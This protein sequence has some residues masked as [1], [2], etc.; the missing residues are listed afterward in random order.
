MTVVRPFRAVRYDTKRVDLSKVIVPPY[1][2]IAV[3]ERGSFFD[4]D[5]HNAIRFELTRDAEEE[6]DA[7]Y[8]WIRQT[9][10]DW[11]ESGVLI[12]DDQPSYYVMAQRFTSPSGDILERIGFFAELKLEAY[13]ARVV[14]PHERTLAGPK[15]DRLKLLRAAEANL[16]CVFLLYEDREDELASMLSLALDE[17]ELGSATDRAGV[18]YRLGRL[19][20]A[21]AIERLEGFL[22]AR[23]SVIADGHHRYETALEYRRQQTEAHWVMTPDRGVAV[24]DCVFRECL[25]S[26]ESAACRFIVSFAKSR[27]RVKAEWRKQL[28]PDW[29]IRRLNDAFGHTGS[30]RSAIGSAKNSRRWPPGFHLCFAVEFGRVDP[31]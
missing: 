11:R 22:A 9:L 19:T 16:S 1:D 7:S 3:D 29:T 12:Q 21:T 26:G 25:C 4:L 10:D 30:D 13:S 27:L 24:D 18:E 28:L 15:A 17:N 20:D 2:V 14:R 8:G 31:G 5:P 23:P 6:A